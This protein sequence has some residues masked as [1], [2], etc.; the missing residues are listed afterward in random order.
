MRQVM[1]RWLVVAVGILLV[2][3]CA[4]FAAAQN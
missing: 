1:T 3:A 2:A 4:L